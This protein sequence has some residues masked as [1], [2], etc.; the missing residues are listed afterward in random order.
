M[1]FRFVDSV[2]S[3]NKNF[4]SPFSG[5]LSRTGTSR[6]DCRFSDG[7][8]CSHKWFLHSNN[9][10]Q[11]SYPI[12]INKMKL[13]PLPPLRPLPSEIKSRITAA[14]Q[15]TRT[16]RQLLEQRISGWLTAKVR[17]VLPL[18][19]NLVVLLCHKTKAG[20]LFDLFTYSNSDIFANSSNQ[21]AEQSIKMKFWINLTT[22]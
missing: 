6:P 4:F 18:N 7:R 21:N 11:P 2:L 15:V 3:I 17:L 13:S 20:R 16:D 1:W 10:P 5:L 14:R 8:K 12:I 22:E 19:S 9:Q